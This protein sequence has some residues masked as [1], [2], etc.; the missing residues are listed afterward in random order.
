M[1]YHAQGYDGAVLPH[2]LSVIGLS[3]TADN[4]D[5]NGFLQIA[6]LSSPLF[7]IIKRL[8]RIFAA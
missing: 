8:L 7:R 1:Q 4:A 6:T 5:P 3:R 2:V